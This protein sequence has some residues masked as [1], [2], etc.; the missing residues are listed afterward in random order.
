MYIETRY[1]R[2]LHERL[3]RAEHQVGL[4]WEIDRQFGWEEEEGAQENK[5][6]QGV[7]QGGKTT[8]CVRSVSFHVYA[9]S[10]AS[11]V[12]FEWPVQS[13]Q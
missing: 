5:I 2:G 7:G 11:S 3:Q 10:C 1:L 12:V 4:I 8:V 6:K 13:R 9:S